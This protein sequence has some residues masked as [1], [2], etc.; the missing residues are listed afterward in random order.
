MN[1]NESMNNLKNTDIFSGY[2]NYN[3]AHNDDIM[4]EDFPKPNFDSF[5]KYSSLDESS[6]KSLN[7]SIE[8]SKSNLN[9]SKMFE[10]N[11]INIK[12]GQNIFKKDGEILKIKNINKLFQKEANKITFNSNN[13]IIPNEESREI[14]ENEIKQKRLLSNRESAK[15]SR[16]KKKA[17]LENLEKQYNQLKAEYINI[18][19]NQKLCTNN[20]NNNLI[21]NNVRDNLI[22][23]KD[24]FKFDNKKIRDEN[25]QNINYINNQKKIMDNIL[26]NQI[27]VMT[28]IH[29][30]SLQNKF[31]KLNKFEN[32]DNF[33]TIKNKINSNLEII[34]EL[35]DISENENDKNIIKSTKGY[36]LFEFYSNIALLL[37]KYEV[38]YKS[39]ETMN[40]L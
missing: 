10:K 34:K 39:I 16:L 11:N 35:Y 22:N 26:I 30:K 29:I 27:E 17:Y 14:I 40:F 38:I 23:E 18:I 12:N 32:S 37:N 7:S 5:D 20:H 13:I 31:L 8:N 21:E 6:I 36:K 19:E 15:K 28:P 2:L 9:K 4:N 24:C 25:I 3:I 1:L 33:Q